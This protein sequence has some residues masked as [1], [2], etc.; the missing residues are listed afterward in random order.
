MG[1]ATPEGRVL[2]EQPL[3]HIESEGLA[4][5]VVIAL[6]RFRKGELVDGSVRVKD[7]EE[8]LPL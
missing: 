7:I 3:L 6:L 2:L 5:V 8:S 1:F 4:F